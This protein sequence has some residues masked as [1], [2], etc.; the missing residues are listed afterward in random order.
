M[1]YNPFSL[2]GKTILVTGASS[3]IGKAT[4]IECS[5]MGATLVITGRNKERLH[6]VYSLLN[7]NNHLQILADLTET[8][9][10]DNI[11][12]NVPKL[13]GIV[14]SAGKSLTLPIPFCSREKFDSYFDINFFSPVEIIRLLYKKKILKN[15]SSIVFI[16]S[17]GG[18]TGFNPG[19]SIYGASKA[20]LNSFMRFCANEFAS[21]KIRVNSIC[22]G[23]I[24]TPLIHRG[25]ITEDQLKEFANNYLLKR[26]GTVEEIAWGAI[27]FLSDASAWTTG[28]SLIINGGGQ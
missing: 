15:A 6:E 20:A 3:G 22:P 27:Y 8:Q 14:L 10:I 25:T 2:E 26:F 9:D 11:I 19:N 28:T 5:K 7:G 23:M 16:S 4:A 24:D 18:V 12:K 17:V 21:R 13:D 1:S